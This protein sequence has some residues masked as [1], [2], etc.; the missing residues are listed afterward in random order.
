MAA[1]GSICLWEASTGQLQRRFGY[2][3]PNYPQA[4]L[5]FAPDNKTLVSRIGENTTLWDVLTGKEVHIRRPWHDRKEI[6]DI[7]FAAGGKSV[8]ILR[9][10]EV[11]L[12]EF[13]TDKDIRTFDG[14]KGKRL[15]AV[16]I[17]S[18]GQTL[19]CSDGFGRND[20]IHVWNAATGKERHC[21]EG[22]QFFESYHIALSPEGRFLATGGNSFQGN[23]IR[24]WDLTTGKELR[25]FVGDRPVAFSADSGTLVCLNGKHITFYETATGKPLRVLEGLS[26]EYDARQGQPRA[27]AVSS[28]G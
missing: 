1:G 6:A 26:I 12:R 9:H 5:A 2:R 19:V 18:D 4:G 23:P 8:A 14:I 15:E 21:I 17:S 7:A 3:A 11:C 25:G 10:N 22:L 20:V 16:A 24:L 27:F 13:G 28:D